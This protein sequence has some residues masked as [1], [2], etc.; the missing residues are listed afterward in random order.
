MKKIDISVCILG[1]IFTLA[2]A[3]CGEWNFLMRAFACACWG[4]T[5]N[6]VKRQD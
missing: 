1:I 4:W 3:F 5:L 6:I 2:S